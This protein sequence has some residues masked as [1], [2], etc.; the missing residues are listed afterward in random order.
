MDL[1]NL[2]I[3]YLNGI[4]RVFLWY[5]MLVIDNFFGIKKE[6]YI[7]VELLSFFYWNLL[8]FRNIMFIWFIYIND[9]NVCMC[10][11]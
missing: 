6:C 4:D 5:N 8:N 2:I 1:W 10:I 3:L 9:F 7:D 11:I